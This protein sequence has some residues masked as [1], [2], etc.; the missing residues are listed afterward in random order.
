[1]LIPHPNP[2]SINNC[3][4]FCVGDGAIQPPRTPQSPRLQKVPC[5][6]VVRTAYLTSVRLAFLI[7]ITH[8]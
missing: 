8:K 4:F 5:N 1:M 2:C 3:G 7:W 6:E